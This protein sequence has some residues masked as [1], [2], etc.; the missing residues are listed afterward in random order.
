MSRIPNTYSRYLLLILLL[1]SAGS[2][3]KFLDAPAGDDIVPKTTSELSSLFNWEG[4]PREDKHFYSYLNMLDDDVKCD[5]RNGDKLLLRYGKSVFSWSSS[6][7]KDM[8]AATGEESIYGRYYDRIKGCNVV[9]DLLPEVKGSAREKAT[10][11]GEAK[12]L[13]AY[14]YFMLVNLYGRPYNDSGSNPDRSLG[15]PLVITSKLSGAP[16]QRNTVGAIYRQVSK[17]ITQGCELL[18]QGDAPFSLLRV[19]KYMAWLLASRVFLYTEEWDKVVYYSSKLLAE[20]RELSDLSRMADGTGIP[21]SLPPAC[22]DEVNK[23]L[24]FLYGS[25]QDDYLITRPV[26]QTP[27]GFVP[28]DELMGSYEREDLRVRYYMQEKNSLRKSAKLSSKAKYGRSFRLPEAFLNRAEAN[29]HLAIYD[30][31]AGAL[32]AALEDLNFLRANRL[33][34]NSYRPK[35]MAD[36]QGSAWSLKIFCLEERRRELCF[37]EQ[38]WFDLRR[39]GMP[40]LLHVYYTDPTGQAE[41]FTLDAHSNRYVLP[42]PD[43]AIAQN[44]ALV[45]N[46]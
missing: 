30:G 40:A 11:E 41:P 38:R 45:Q 20:R 21:G 35:T 43:D 26:S 32:A 31:K 27:T 46:P 2:C 37:E 18:E 3:R 39:N 36:F 13:R 42:I 29:I 6:M 8:K 24:L 17:D 34:L 19:N 10:L 5:A 9:L 25:P 15:V 12:I 4:Y 33:S 7:Y 1:S 14:Y 22:L 23:E 28:S 16:L 44:P